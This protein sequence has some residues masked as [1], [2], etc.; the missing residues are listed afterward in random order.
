MSRDELAERV[1]SLNAER[2]RPS[3]QVVPRRPHRS[4]WTQPL[5]DQT[6]D[7]SILL[8]QLITTL[9]QLYTTPPDEEIP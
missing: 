9:V 7:P 1:R 5:P 2:A 6:A 3:P 4:L 8:Q